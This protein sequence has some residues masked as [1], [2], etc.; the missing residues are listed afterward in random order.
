MKGFAKQCLIL[1]PF[2][3][4]VETR[5]IDL[6]KYYT[7]NICNYL[8][9]INIQPCVFN[10]NEMAVWVNNEK[11]KWLCA[12]VQP[13]LS[14]V[15]RGYID[16]LHDVETGKIFENYETL[17]LKK[18]PLSRNQSVDERFAYVVKRCEMLTS[19]IIQQL[20]FIITFESRY[21]EMYKV[22]EGKSNDGRIIFRIDTLRDK[23][24]CYMSGQAVDYNEITE[25]KFYYK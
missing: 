7:S 6:Y 17:V 9:T 15:R 8:N 18:F 1:Y 11:F 22:K 25:N 21:N 20:K 24:Q 3:N 13:D 23:I 12:F 10:N 4:K 2:I 14:F 19:L 16:M 5:D